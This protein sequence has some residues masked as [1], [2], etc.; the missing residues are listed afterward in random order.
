MDNSNKEYLNYS[1]Y[2]GRNIQESLKD[3]VGLKLNSKC[4][5]CVAENDGGQYCKF[6]GTSLYETQIPN[7]TT[8]FKFR[9]INTKPIVLA[10]I[11]SFVMLF[12]V[13]L[14]LKLSIG[15]DM[16]EASKFINPLHIVLGMNLGTINLNIATMM[17]SGGVGIHLGVIVI[18]LMPIAAIAISNLIFINNKSSEDVLYNSIGLGLMYGLILVIISILSSTSSSMSNIIN[19][20][21]SVTY[22]Y[23]IWELFINGFFLGFI[24]TYLIGY[25]KKYL[26]QNI[27]LDILKKAINTILIL[28]IAIFIILFG[29]IMLDRS[30]VYELNLYGYSNSTS[31]IISQLALYVLYFANIISVSIGSNKLSIISLLNGDL[32]FNTKIMFMAMIFLSLL[33]LIITGYNLR[34]KLKDNQQ[35]VVFIFS[36][37]YSILLSMLSSLS[38]IYIGGNMS[39]LQMS[40]YPGNTFMGTNIF[41]TLI[42]SFIYSYI[43][44]KIG[45]TLSDFE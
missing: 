31:L 24:S 15:T 10:S 36:I 37:C 33:V 45:Y 39:L 6:C 19:Y 38:M 8:K 34:K 43:I 11:S 29:I 22:R 41:T 5:S 14:G 13:A 9:K 25:R 16:G 7:S 4:S 40:S 3:K 30:Y 35:N 12:I 17:G 1:K 21:I 42:V 28:Y 27:Y 44:V 20:G 18:A 2:N 26:S 23:R 32:F